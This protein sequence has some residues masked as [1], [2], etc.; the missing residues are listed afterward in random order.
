MPSF[1][2]LANAEREAGVSTYLLNETK[3][4]VNS[5]GDKVLAVEVLQQLEREQVTR[6]PLDLSNASNYSWPDAAAVGRFRAPG[7]RV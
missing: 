6:T 4:H 3:M 1:W 5:L 2:M 7:N